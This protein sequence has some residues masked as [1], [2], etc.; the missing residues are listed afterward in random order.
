MFLAVL[1]A[2]LILFA[3]ASYVFWRIGQENGIGPRWRNSAA[4]ISLI[5][6][7]VLGGWSGGAS[8]VILSIVAM[9]LS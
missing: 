3:L 1:F 7:I 8:L 5:V 4:K 2:G 9:I 6:L